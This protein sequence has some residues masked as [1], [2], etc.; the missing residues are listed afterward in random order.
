MRPK[1]RLLNQDDEMDLAA[2]QKWAVD[3]WLV[4]YQ[5]RVRK[6]KLKKLTVK[7]KILCEQPGC[8]CSEIS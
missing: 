3:V 4:E 8:L 1:I 2:F 7:F 5:K 6:K